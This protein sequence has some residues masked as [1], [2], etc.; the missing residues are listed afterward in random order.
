M[1]KGVKKQTSCKYKITTVALWSL[2]SDPVAKSMQGFPINNKWCITSSCTG[3]SKIGPP[4]CYRKSHANF[5][6]PVS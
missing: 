4:F 1:R 2:E 3:N 5:A 6:I